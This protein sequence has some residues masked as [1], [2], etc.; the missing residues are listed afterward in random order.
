M[1]RIRVY[2]GKKGFTIEF[3]LL[4]FVLFA[5]LI[6]SKFVLQY[7]LVF[8]SILFHEAAHIA[9]AKIFGSKINSIRILP[10]GL[11]ASIDEEKYSFWKTVAIY[12][13]GPLINLLLFALS[14]SINSFLAE[15]YYLFK[16]NNMSFFIL[17]NLY[18]AIF[19]LL[20]LLPLDGGKILY[21]II[22]G[23][24]GLI[25]AYGYTKR[26]SSVLAVLLVLT[27]L[28]QL[29]YNVLD[30]SLLLVGI[31]IIFYLRS[32]GMEAAIMNMKNIIF[33]H[34]RLLKKGFYPARDL[35]VLQTVRISELIKSMD[36]DSFHM[37]HVLDEELKV[38]RVFTEKE[39]MDGMVKL[40]SDITFEELINLSV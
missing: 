1:K 3:D 15:S 2:K 8:I 10:V 31:Y 4:F 28:M 20:P 32:Q 26:I 13:S 11:N 21:E 5:L 40:S 34:S 22:S 25:K 23:R 7:L 38:I 24:L 35:V 39:L 12:I 6:L 36:F 19:N 33:R 14:I 9:V 37:I 29:M 30:F 27:G 17:S 18:L 16:N